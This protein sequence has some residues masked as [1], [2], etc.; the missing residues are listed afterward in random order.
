M[1]NNI[2]VISVALALW[3]IVFAIVKYFEVAAY[4]N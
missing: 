1:K 4:V 2:F 3:V